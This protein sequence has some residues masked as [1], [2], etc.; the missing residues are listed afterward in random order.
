[1]INVG[2]KARY[3]NF[4]QKRLFL[5]CPVDTDDY[6]ESKYVRTIRSALEICDLGIIVTVEQIPATNMNVYKYKINEF[7]SY[8]FISRLRDITTYGNASSR[9]ILHIL[10]TAIT[11]HLGSAYEQELGCQFQVSV[12]ECQSS[13]IDIGKRL[14][15]QAEI[16]FIKTLTNLIYRRAV[17]PAIARQI[18]MYTE[19]YFTSRSH[20]YQNVDEFGNPHLF[21]CGFDFGN[22]ADNICSMIGG[23][24]IDSDGN[25]EFENINIRGE[26]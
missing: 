4:A 14:L 11:N 8:S 7:P 1:M 15:E 21:T 19:R 9:N 17:L 5:N 20:A 10:S 25:G 12:E 24:N 22:S 26:W 6:G 13:A 18:V 16:H 23:W 3:D 2:Y